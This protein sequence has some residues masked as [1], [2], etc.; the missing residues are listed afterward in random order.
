M[1]LIISAE[2]R[3]QYDHDDIKNGEKKIEKN[4]IQCPPPR[5]L[6]RHNYGEVLLERLKG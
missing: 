5:M 2:Q 1:R 3:R 4:R 6:A